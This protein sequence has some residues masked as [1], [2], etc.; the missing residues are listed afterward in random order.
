MFELVQTLGPRRKLVPNI[1]LRKAKGITVG[2][3]VGTEVGIGVGDIV[4]TNVGVGG[5]VTQLAPMS[6][7]VLAYLIQYELVP[8]S[9]PVLARRLVWALVTTLALAM[10]HQSASVSEPRDM[11]S[12]ARKVK[13]KAL[14]RMIQRI[15]TI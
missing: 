1:I 6:A 9:E 2:D 4:G 10:E 7:S 13:R 3:L 8:V 12:T 11:G 15:E 14:T 5:L